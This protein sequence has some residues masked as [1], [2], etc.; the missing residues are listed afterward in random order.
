MSDA[1]RPVEF[2]LADIQGNILTAYGRLGFPKG[3]NLCFNVRDSAKGRRFIETLVPKV[4]TA[5]RWSSRKALGVGRLE[6]PR[7][8]VA[9]NVA[10]TFEGLYACGVP[11][12]T[13]RG[14]PDEFIHGMVARAALLGDDFPAGAVAQWDPVWLGQ[15][16]D[17]VHILVMLNAQMDASTG[18]P[19]PELAE[20]TDWLRQLCAELGGVKLLPGHGSDGGEW[21]EL[22][23]VLRHV[24]DHYE[25]TP[26]EHLG[27]LDGI[28]DPV[29]EGQ[30]APK[31]EAIR[32]RGNG[33]LGAS[34]SWE[35]L[36][37]GEFLLGYP[38]ESQEIA[39]G[40]M[41]LPFARNGTFM[42]YRKLEEN[43]GLFHQ[44]L[45]EQA[46]RFGAVYGIDD[47][48][49]ARATLMAKFAGRWADGVPL[50][51]APTFAD[52]QRF[53]NATSND[54]RAGFALTDYTYY[55]DP[56]G[57][58]CPVTSHVRRVNPR[59][60]MGPEPPRAN[61][62]GPSGTALSNRRR[63][64]RR[65]LPYGT[66]TPGKPEPKVGIVML[67]VCA[68][69]FRQFEFVQQQ[70][71]NYGLD[72][73]AG[74]DSCPLLGNHGPGAKFVV[75]ADPAGGHAPFVAPAIPQFV[76]A[77]GGAYFFVPS[78]PALAMIGTGAIDPT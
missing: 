10:L 47:P 1:T 70:W 30:Y 57:L 55:D 53:N 20:T 64:L 51:L 54:A 16:Q 5:L 18:L 61:G 76:E 41:P 32:V 46:P 7:P 21:Q 52:W 39:P 40:P 36:A 25:A 65:G 24:D 73:S 9:I 29:F 69:L 2:N 62:P 48:A 3:R 58:R 19:V 8:K 34:G 78:L 31:D 44:Y 22:S 43:V 27:Y 71:L 28:S 49:A 77:R 12:R 38:D 13:L 17:A 26:F 37:A 75:P 35:P 4:T 23:A 45:D 60:G 74:N 67:C 66:G 33:K 56:G 15:G 50:A 72:A 68:S 11:V 6:V 14:F 42:A 63:I 59:D